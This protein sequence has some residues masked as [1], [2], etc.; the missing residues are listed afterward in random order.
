MALSPF[1]GLSAYFGFETS[2]TLPELLATLM[3]EQEAQIL[4]ATPGTPHVLAR[5]LCYELY[6]T[7]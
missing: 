7:D 1:R 2:K 4:L 5:M 3:S 6:V